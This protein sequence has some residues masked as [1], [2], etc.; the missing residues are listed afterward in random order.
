MATKSYQLNITKS[1]GTS[2][3]VSF[4]IPDIEGTYKVKFALSDGQEIDA[5]NITVDDAEHSYDLKLTLSDGS[6]INAGIITTPVTAPPEIFTFSETNTAATVTGLT[7]HGKTLNEIV[8]PTEHNAKPVTNIGSSAFRGCTGLTSITIPDSVTSIGSSAF[9][10]CSGLTSIT[11]PDSVTSIRSS[12]F[13]NCSSLTSITI[14]DSVTSI[15][16]SAFQNCT[17]LT[18]ITIPSGVTSIGSNVFYNCSGL[19]S[20]IVAQD[21]PIYHSSGNCIIETASKTLISGCQN[22]VI[23][24][25]GSV[26]SIGNDAF[27]GCSGLTSITIP[28]S[29]TSIGE[30]AFS[31]CSGLTS[32]TIPDSVTSIGK[33]ALYGCTRLT[34]INYAGTQSQ[35]Q[36]I[37]KVY[38]WNSNTGNYTVHCTDGDISKADS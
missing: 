28:G 26:T 24:D 21:N 27:S 5:G 29:V 9:R 31:Y 16:S 2:E 4:V 23:P 11:I 8:I 10:D 37:S 30:W 32:I 13:Y 18:S 3:T 14:P 1:D 20:I 34:S 12:T 38:S 6:T 33:Y 17:G 7:D 36:G 15:G 22:S 35:W 25:D 19:T